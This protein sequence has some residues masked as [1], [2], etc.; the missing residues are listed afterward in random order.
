[1]SVVKNHQ[2][3]FNKQN[4]LPTA[5][6][7]INQSMHVYKYGIMHHFNYHYVTLYHTKKTSVTLQRSTDETVSNQRLV[8]YQT[9]GF[10]HMFNNKD[11]AEVIS[12][13]R[14]TQAVVVKA[15]ESIVGCR[16]TRTIRDGDGTINTTVPSGLFTVCHQV[17]K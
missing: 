8:N 13:R 5:S 3:R 2:M 17:N 1:M 6:P 9:A 7:S 11:L 12:G 14:R 4:I 15:R 16:V 10:E